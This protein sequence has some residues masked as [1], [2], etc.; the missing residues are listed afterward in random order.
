MPDRRLLLQG[1]AYAAFA[2]V[3]V[4][5]SVWPVYRPLGE[6]E[7]LLRLSM[8]VSGS[9]V[10]E[11]RVVT[12]SELSRLPPNM[13]STEECPR[14]R[15]PVRFELALDGHPL[16]DETVGPR[17]LARDGDAVIHRRISVAAGEHRVSVRVDPDA[18]RPGAVHQT[19]R[20]L[21]LAP[22]ALLT[23]DFDRSRGGVVLQ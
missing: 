6:D 11:C 5:F 22:G 23:I 14:E 21:T 7:A 10:G 9:I 2:A 1:L 8:S 18:V 19:E 16:V 4:L 15:A 12:A 17:G 3:L 13:R 20:M